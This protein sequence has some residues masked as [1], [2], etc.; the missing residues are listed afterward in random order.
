VFFV[1]PKFSPSSFFV[2]S[3][4]SFFGSVFYHPFLACVSNFGGIASHDPS[5]HPMKMSPPLSRGLSLHITHG[6]FLSAS[7]QASPICRS[8]QNSKTRREKQRE[9]SS[10]RLQLSLLSSPPDTDC[11]RKQSK[12]PFPQTP[13]GHPC[14]YFPPTIWVATFPSNRS[15][16]AP[17]TSFL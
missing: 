6:F 15:L 8:L 9:V 13:S 4:L 10:A 7:P 3:D 5:R 16:E 11:S 1:T 12:K 2:R 14:C 17:L